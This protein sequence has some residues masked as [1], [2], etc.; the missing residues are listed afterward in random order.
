MEIIGEREEENVPPENPCRTSCSG[1]E[2]AEEATTAANANIVHNAE[3]G[4]ADEKPLIQV[5]NS[6]TVADLPHNTNNLEHNVEVNSGVAVD[7]SLVT[8]QKNKLNI[9]THVHD[10]GYNSDNSQTDE[11]SIDNT[12]QNEKPSKFDLNQEDLSIHIPQQLIGGRSARISYF[13]PFY[14]TE[15]EPISKIR[16]NRRAAQNYQQAVENRYI[17]AED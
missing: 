2:C 14:A 16:E 17:T 15:A 10:Y 8:Q 12:S 6:A 13:E 4:T 9:K 5:L 1:S 7:Y 3:V 11:Q